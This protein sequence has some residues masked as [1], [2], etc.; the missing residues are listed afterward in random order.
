VILVDANLLIYAGVSSMPEHDGARRWFDQ[1]L[2]GTAPVGLPWQSLLAY[3][4]ITTN[5]RAIARPQRMKDA[6]QQVQ[7]W[8]SCPPAW[9]P[10]P[11]ERHA[12]EFCALCESAEVYGD[13]VPDAHL[14]TLAMEHGL[15]L[16]SSDRDFARFPKL[17]WMNPLAENR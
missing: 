11:T 6:W 13:L 17:R 1:Q 5:P 10:S 15:I 14:A 16:C 4:R 12:Q 2:N 7:D 3:L 8:L 9:I